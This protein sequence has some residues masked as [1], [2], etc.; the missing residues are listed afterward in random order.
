VAISVDW[1]VFS[2]AVTTRAELAALDATNALLSAVE[3]FS[4]T[5]EAMELAS[6]ALESAVE[7]LTATEL[8][9]VDALSALVSAREAAED[10]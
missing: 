3:V 2:D 6:T 8:A 4:E 7:V 5:D 10:A 9:R 1:D